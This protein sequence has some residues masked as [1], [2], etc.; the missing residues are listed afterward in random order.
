MYGK[1]TIVSL[2]EPKNHQI[3]ALYN[4]SKI[5]IGKSIP[6]NRHASS[7][8]DAE[9]LEFT[10]GK[11]R[12][13]SLEL[14]FDSFEAGLEPNKAGEI[15]K[16]VHKEYVAKLE[17]LTE[18]TIKVK[19]KEGKEAT[20]PHFIIVVWGEFP[21]FRGVLES[22][23]VEYTMFFANGRPARATCSVKITEVVAAQLKTEGSTES[24]A[25]QIAKDAAKLAAWKKPPAPPQSNQSQNA[26]GG[27]ASGGAASG[28]ASG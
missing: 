19:G 1:C 18:P 27:A 5:K 15:G 14:F 6:W 10:S 8:G 3:E 9:M 7:G 25:D 21:P 11:N 24:N 23:D 28:G 17:A 20:R 13:L 2:D 4:P 22:V 26:S 12:S 16:D